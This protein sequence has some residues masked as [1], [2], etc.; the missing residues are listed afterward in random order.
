MLSQKGCVVWVYGLS[1]SGKSTLASALE[2]K[3]FAQGRV[4]MI[5]DGDCI[6]TGL[7][8]DLSFSDA[9]RAENLRRIAE[10]ARLFAEAGVLCICSFISPFR[11]SREFAS[12]VIGPDRFLEVFVDTPL[13]VC[14]KRDCK[15]LYAKARAGSIPHFTGISAPFERPEDPEA[16]VMDTDAEGLEPCV[17]KLHTMLQEKGFIPREG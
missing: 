7:C 15:G 4:T 11:K 6:R 12:E 13:E 3:L 9:D 14:E 1:G 8:K 17:D 5:L 10:V 2:K 16:L